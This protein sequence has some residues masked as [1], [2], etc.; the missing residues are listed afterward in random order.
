MRS[1]ACD[2]YG[3]YGISIWYVFMA[4]AELEREPSPGIIG[5]AYASGG[6]YSLP[7]NGCH[8]TLHHVT[9]GVTNNMAHNV[10]TCD[11]RGMANHR[12]HPD[13]LPA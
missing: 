2:P 11:G 7:S 9:S 8:I 10:S 6:R 5:G 1:Y 12:V 13:T 4:I 3:T